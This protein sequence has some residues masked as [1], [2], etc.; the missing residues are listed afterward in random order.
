MAMQT[1]STTTQDAGVPPAPPEAHQRAGEGCI[2]LSAAG[3]QALEAVMIRT[4]GDEE[5]ALEVLLVEEAARVLAQQIWGK[6]IQ[7]KAGGLYA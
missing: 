6:S 1:T 3:R 2:R 7:C 4:G 5:G